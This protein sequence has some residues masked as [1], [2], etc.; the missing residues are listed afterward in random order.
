MHCRWP[1]V[2][3]TEASPWGSENKVRNIEDHLLMGGVFTWERGCAFSNGLISVAGS[4]PGGHWIMWSWITL[5]WEE[6]WL[7][8]FGLK[9][10]SC[11]FLV[12]ARRKH[13][14]QIACCYTDAI[15]LLL[16][17]A[18]SV[19]FFFLKSVFLAFSHFCDS[20]CLYRSS[21]CHGYD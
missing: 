3:P 5:T 2:R 17:E 11:V 10:C 14:N 8:F 16:I 4:C 1:C 15:F 19:C 13:S 12:I 9:S 6:T 18:L 20:N 7:S 21:L